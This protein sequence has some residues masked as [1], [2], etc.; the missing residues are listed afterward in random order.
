LLLP[1]RNV[2]RCVTRL[3]HGLCHVGSKPYRTVNGDA[4]DRA[5]GGSHRAM[6]RV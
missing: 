5:N 6:F 1:G 2:F 3:L 4:A